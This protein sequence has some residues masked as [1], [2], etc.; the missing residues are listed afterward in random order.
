MSLRQFDKIGREHIDRGITLLEKE[1]LPLAYHAEE[2]I[3]HDRNFHIRALLHSSRQLSRG[4]LE[5]AIAR[6][7]PDL[8]IFRRKP[9]TNRG[10]ETKAHRPR[11]ARGEPTIRFLES[12]ILGCPHLMLTYV[13]GHDRA[14]TRG[15]PNICDEMRDI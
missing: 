5:S 8:L 12:I 1:L 3:V 15:F 10:R 13:C 9:G 14:S 7:C 11:A 4:H 2:I 6:D